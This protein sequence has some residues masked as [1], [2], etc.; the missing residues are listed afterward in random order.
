MNLTST[1]VVPKENSYSVWIMGPINS[2]SLVVDDMKLIINATSDGFTIVM[3]KLEL[4]D[5]YGY[6]IH[7]VSIITQ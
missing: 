4:I 2:I 7:W 1:G 3:V 5:N 6:S